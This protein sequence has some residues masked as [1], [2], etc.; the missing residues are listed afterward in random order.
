MCA[1]GFRAGSC[2]IKECTFYYHQVVGGPECDLLFEQEGNNERFSRVCDLPRLVFWCFDCIC[3]SCIV[4][5]VV[6]SLNSEFCDIFIVEFVFSVYP[7]VCVVDLY[8]PMYGWAWQ[9]S[10]GFSNLSSCKNN[11]M[12][13]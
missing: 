5:C 9:M 3:T 10:L 11:T 6:P 8:R 7:Y 12:G 2:T 4:P 13:Q 1:A